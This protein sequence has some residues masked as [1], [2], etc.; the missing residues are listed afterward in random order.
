MLSILQQI[1]LGLALAMDC[2]SVSIATGIT[3]KR[4]V[5]R[6]MLTMIFC[7][8]LFQALMP[9]AGYFIAHSFSEKI[10]SFD[11]WTAFFLLGAI[12]FNMIKEAV[13]D[14]EVGVRLNNTSI[15]EL[16]ALSVAT[17][18]DALAA[19]I[20]FALLDV[21]IL[22]SAG[23]IGIITFFLSIAGVCTGYLFG[24]RFEKKS[25]IAGGIILIIIGLKTLISHVTQL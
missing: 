24:S 5:P 22:L 2:F 12:G 21:N 6:A 15:K 3:L 14:N 11:H 18:I 16:L 4:F 7:F 25:E 17:S 10:K 20:G 23:I 8:G 19:G 1:L 13:N 9:C